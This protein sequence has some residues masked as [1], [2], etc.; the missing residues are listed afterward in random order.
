M[1]RKNVYLV[2]NLYVYVWRFKRMYPNDKAFFYS[3]ASFL[4][5]GA[6][7]DELEKNNPEAEDVGLQGR[8]PDYRVLRREIA[9]RAFH[10][11]WRVRTAWETIG[12]H[13]FCHA[14]IGYLHAHL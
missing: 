12:S 11:L 3:A 13:V 8:S 1:L 10:S 7:R 5:G 2:D 6:A 9:K 4:D 14:K